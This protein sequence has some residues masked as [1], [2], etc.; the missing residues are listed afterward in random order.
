M[1]YPTPR[2]DFVVGINLTAD[3]HPVENCK[4]FVTCNALHPDYNTLHF[5]RFLRSRAIDTTPPLEVQLKYE[6]KRGE[7]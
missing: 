1:T 5:G 6:Q 4:I 3:S 7:D 2:P